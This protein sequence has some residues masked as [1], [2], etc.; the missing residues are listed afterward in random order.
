MCSSDLFPSHDIGMQVATW[1]E[2]CLDGDFK[3]FDTTMK[4][5]IIVHVFEVFSAIAKW[6]GMYSEEDLQVIHL[7]GQDTAYPLFEFFGDVMMIFGMNP[8]GNPATVIINGFANSIYMRYVYIC[9]NVEH[10]VRDFKKYVHLMTYGDDNWQSVSPDKR[11]ASELTAQQ[12][13]SSQSGNHKCN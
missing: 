8:S 11:A 2:R 5:R 13:I 4:A 9:A 3:D 12:Q 1:P 7:I 10:Y 6:S